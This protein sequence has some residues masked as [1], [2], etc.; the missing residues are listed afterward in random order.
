MTRLDIKSTNI[1]YINDF[2]Q[3]THRIEL[4]I[5]PNVIVMYIYTHKR[6]NWQVKLLNMKL[7][8]ISYI[9]YFS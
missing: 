2:S 7:T 4:Q 5:L 1:Y 3:V 8:A 9:K 6:L